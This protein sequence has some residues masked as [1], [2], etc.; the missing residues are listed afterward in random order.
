M[1]V[2]TGLLSSA[3]GD[4]ERTSDPDAGQGREAARAVRGPRATATDT[5]SFVVQRALSHP[6]QPRS[7]PGHLR[8]PVP[9]PRGQPPPRPWCGR[10][11]Y[12]PATFS[13]DAK[14]ARPPLRGRPCEAPP[15]HLARGHRGPRRAHLQFLKNLVGR[16]AFPLSHGD[17]RLLLQLRAVGGAA[18][19][20]DF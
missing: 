20:F 2:V 5:A 19:S 9:S 16:P 17:I 14:E 7:S 4:L 1:D 12:L 13:E 3:A 11:V 15:G 18:L 8:D 6:R 10:T